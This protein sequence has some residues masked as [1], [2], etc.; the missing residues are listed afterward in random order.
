MVAKKKVKD[1]DKPRALSAKGEK[2]RAGLK[3][4]A[5]NVLE[6]VGYHKMRI[7]DVTGEAGVAAGLFYH[8]FN[9]LKSL[10]QEVLLDFVSHSLRLEDIERDVPKGDWYQRILVHNRLVVRAYA[11]RPGI[12]RCLLQMA[13]EDEHFAQRLRD[14]YRQQLCW[15]TS[16]MPRLFPEAGFENN[17]QQALLLVYSLAGSSEMLLRDYFINQEEALTAAALDAEE[18][19]EL[20]SVM[21]YRG[22]FLKNPPQEQLHY[23]R[24]LSVMQR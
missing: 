8:Y 6:R 16:V 15:L 4:A 3:T 24:N 11:Q 7:A 12:M 5:L 20:L 18:M 14:N 1:S 10:T 23:T 9:D 17:P 21:F 13:D 19:A 22:L 2:A